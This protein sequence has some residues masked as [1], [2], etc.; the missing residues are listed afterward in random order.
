MKTISVMGFAY[1]FVFAEILWFLSVLIK[2]SNQG[3]KNKVHTVGTAILNLAEFA[4]KAEEK[5]FSLNIPLAVSGSGSETRPALC[6]C[7]SLVARLFR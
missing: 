4:A 2:V 5:E 1:C 7:N 6:V 3:A